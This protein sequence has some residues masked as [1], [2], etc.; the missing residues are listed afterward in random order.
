MFKPTSIDLG[1][2]AGLRR[3]HGLTSNVL[4]NLELHDKGLLTPAALIQRLRFDAYY[5]NLAHVADDNRQPSAIDRIV[6][7]HEL[8]EQARASFS[9]EAEAGFD[10]AA[11]DSMGGCW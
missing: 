6:D 7:R 4:H 5:L 11:F 1:S 10:R 8:P 3:C 2:P 9:C